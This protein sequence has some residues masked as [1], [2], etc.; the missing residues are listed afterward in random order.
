M[1][2]FG[3]LKCALSAHNIPYEE[4]LPKVWKKEMGLDSDKEKSRALAIKLYPQCK[5]SLKR[6]KDHGRAEALL[7]LNYWGGLDGG[8]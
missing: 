3:V 5:D 8:N 1:E 6:K 2:Q 4:V 7:L